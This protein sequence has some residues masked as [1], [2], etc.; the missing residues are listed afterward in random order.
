MQTEFSWS[1]H[2]TAV[3]SQR[4]RFDPWHLVWTGEATPSD[5]R[6]VA[7]LEALALLARSRRI[8]GVPVGVIGP[9]LATDNQLKVAEALGRAITEHGLQLFC[10]GK[11]G[12]MEAACKGSFE[13]GGTPVGLIP[14]DEWDFANPYCAVPIASGIGPA[15]N[16]II[17]RAAMAL[18]AIGGGHGT[19]SEMAFGLHFHRPVMALE[20]APHIDG[21]ERCDSVDQVMERLAQIVLAGRQPHRGVT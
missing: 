16:A 7:P 10:G 11:N 13:A 12:V 6:P 19:L 9:K 17:A 14:D 3:Y 4:G 20:D 2:D 1:D 21:V 5:V 15:R 8:R 18:I